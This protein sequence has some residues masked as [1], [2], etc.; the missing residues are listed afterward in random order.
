MRL[1]FLA[2][3]ANCGTGV[4]VAACCVQPASAWDRTSRLR[5]DTLPGLVAIVR[6]PLGLAGC[7]G[8]VVKSI[9]RA[10]AF[11]SYVLTAKHCTLDPEGSVVTL[12]VA[13]PIAGDR[14]LSVHAPLFPATVAY[15]GSGREAL[16]WHHRLANW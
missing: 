13:A 14:P 12:A 10:S 1:G 11:E 16:R 8:A 3:L 2:R 9:P 5:R 6:Q 7:T 4:L 15:T